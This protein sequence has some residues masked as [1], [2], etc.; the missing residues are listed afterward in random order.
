MFFTYV[1]FLYRKVFALTCTIRYLYLTY[2]EYAILKEFI[3]EFILRSSFLS[4][5]F[6]I[7]RTALHFY[8]LFDLDKIWIYIYA[9]I[10]V[11]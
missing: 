7:K 11:Y 1:L 5:N 4:I 8:I 9:L 6:H 2:V 3:A 10:G